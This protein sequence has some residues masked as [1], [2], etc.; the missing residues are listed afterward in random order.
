MTHILTCIHLHDVICQKILRISVQ[1]RGPAA[2][3]AVGQA[4]ALAAGQVTVQAAGKAAK[5]AG[6]AGQAVGMAGQAVGRASLIGKYSL[7]ISKHHPVLQN[8]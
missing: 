3:Q 2:R 8:D 1:I 5:A 6:Q 7:H 4:Q